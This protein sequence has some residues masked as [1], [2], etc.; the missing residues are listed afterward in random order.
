[1][2]PGAESVAGRITHRG[3]TGSGVFLSERDNLL[4][5]VKESGVHT[6]LLRFA[7]YKNWPYRV[8]SVAIRN[9]AVKDLSDL[10]SRSTASAAIAVAS[11]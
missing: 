8:G 4:G 3:L 7:I 9:E 10:C 11:S 1:M 6:R 2:L 5:E